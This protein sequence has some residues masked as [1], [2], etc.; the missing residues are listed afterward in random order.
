MTYDNGIQEIVSLCRKKVLDGIVS[1]CLVTCGF[2]FL[3]SAL[4]QWFRFL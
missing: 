4:I 1:T 3:L 2:M